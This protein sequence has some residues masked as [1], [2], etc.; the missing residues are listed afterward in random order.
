M[1]IFS[2]NETRRTE[3]ITAQSARVLWSV[4]S[5]APNTIPL[6]MLG[7]R[8][9]YGQKVTPVY[10][11]YSFEN[12]N[13]K[14]LIKG[15]A[16]GTLTCEGIVVKNIPALQGFLDAASKSC[17]EPDEEV[18]ITLYPFGNGCMKGEDTST[19]SYTIKGVDLSQFDLQLQAGQVA[20]ITHSLT[21]TFTD[22]YLN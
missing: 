4:G 19:H 10:P 16:E 11:L 15:A 8:I 22:M 13:V 20:S 17:K 1:Q 18:N 9:S 3:T 5:N 14:L 12:G 2:S 6:Y 21:F 7:V